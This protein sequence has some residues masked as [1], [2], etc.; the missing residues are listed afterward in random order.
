MNNLTGEKGIRGPKVLLLP[1]TTRCNARCIMCTIWKRPPESISAEFVQKTFADG[2]LAGHLEYLGLTGGEPSLLVDLPELT[3]LIIAKAPK[4]KEISLNT[5]GFLSTMVIEIARSLLGM[6]H[7]RNIK[8]VVYVS[9]DGVKEVHDA[10]RGHKGAFEKV[11]YTVKELIN[12]LREK[13]KAE[14]VIN[15]VIN[16]INADTVTDIFKYAKDIGVPINF[17]LV[18]NTDTCI[19]SRGSD[20]EFEIMPGQIHGLIKFF[21]KMKMISRLN[22]DGFLQSLYYQHLLNMLHSVPRDLMCPFSE[23]VGCLVD[24]SGNVYP[25]G[26]SS[27]LYMGNVLETPFGTIWRNKEVR[28]RLNA[29]LPG[30]CAHCESNC[31]IHASESACKT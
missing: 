21:S 9:L 11:E 18:M 2:F 6:T 20:T 28:D 1:V 8:F 30:F 3:K 16:R 7:E 25:C 22:T 15:S 14:V 10:V 29:R 5:N 12:L 4:I 27:E 17:S 23:G 31:F 19:N 26:M 24:S 13:E